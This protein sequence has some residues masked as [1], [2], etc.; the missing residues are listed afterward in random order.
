MRQKH[1]SVLLLSVVGILLCSCSATY[2]SANSQNVPLMTQKGDFIFQGGLAKGDEAE[3]IEFSSAYAISDHFAVMGNTCFYHNNNS[4]DKGTLLEGGVGYYTP[5]QNEKWIFE[6][7]AGFGYGQGSN[8]FDSEHT[9]FKLNR[10]FI[11][12]DFGFS[13]KYFDAIVSVRG[14]FINYFDVTQ[15][16]DTFSSSQQ[17]PYYPLSSGSGYFLV[18]PS[19]TLRMGHKFAKLQ[20]QIGYSEN[21]TD[22]HF[23]QDRIHASGMLVLDLKRSYFQ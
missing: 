9:S 11:Q 21:L 13:T 2:Y 19:F 4:T 1:I 6:T 17:G 3:K 5:L 10:Y 23:Y 12:P 14:A 8:F 22:G 16:Y 18:E 7:Y 20:F 15:Y